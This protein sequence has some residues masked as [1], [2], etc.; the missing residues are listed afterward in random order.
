MMLKTQFSPKVDLSGFGNEL[1]NYGSEVHW[2][3]KE[4]YHSFWTTLSKILNCIKINHLCTSAP[5]FYRAK[6]RFLNDHI[7]TTEDYIHVI[8]VANVWKEKRKEKKNKKVARKSSGFA[9]VCIDCLPPN[10]ASYKI[11]AP[12]PTPPPRTP[13]ILV[14]INE[15]CFW[16]KVNPFLSRNTEKRLTL[17]FTN[18]GM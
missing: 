10:I 2:A 3:S 4:T 12:P 6:K 16:Y 1:F 7:P 15:S 11:P 17:Y 9:Q 5:I 8:Q 13:M 14:P 18:N